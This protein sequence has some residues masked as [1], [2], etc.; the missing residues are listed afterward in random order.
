MATSMPTSMPSSLPKP[1]PIRL[2]F[3]GT[4]AIAKFA[5]AQLAQQ[6]QQPLAMIVRA[7]KESP[8]SKTHPMHISSIDDL[9]SDIDVLVDCAGSEGFF[10]HVPP[11]LTKG[12]NV[13][14]VSLAALADPRCE[15]QVISALGQGGGRLRLVSG[16]IGGLDTLRAARVG[17]LDF[18]KYIG[19]KPPQAW[20][21]SP[22]EQVLDL[23]QLSQPAV[24]F[25]G[26]ARTAAQ[27]YPKNANVAAAV[28]LSALGFDDTTVELIADP[29][30]DENIHAIEAGGKFGRMQ[31]SLSALSLPDNPKSSALAAMSVVAAIL[32]HQEAMA[33]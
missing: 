24:H 33:F 13:I 10:L 1:R 27:N 18:V 30:I 26:T 19:R 17:G 9:P 5:V 6:G 29:G 28:A 20:K 12:I 16:A 7:G 23:D 21:D 4:G 3:I 2:A 31:F 32:D 15:A 25:S 14:S 8:A 11:A 22:A